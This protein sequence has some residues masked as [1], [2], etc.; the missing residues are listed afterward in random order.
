V[1]D[2]DAAI[3]GGPPGTSAM[4][5]VARKTAEAQGRLDALAAAGQPFVPKYRTLRN[6]AEERQRTLDAAMGA[7]WQAMTLDTFNAYTQELRVAAGSV[8]GFIEEPRGILYLYGDMGT[9]KTHLA[10]GTAIRLVERGYPVRVYRASDIVTSI[11]VALREKNLDVLMGRLKHVRV[12]V[13]DDFGAEHMTDFLAA[14]WF[15]LLDYRY[16]QY[17]A[18]IITSNVKPDNLGMPRL[19]SRF[20]DTK[21][22]VVVGITARDYRLMKKQPAMSV[23]ASD[24]APPP[25]DT[26]PCTTCGGLGTVKRDLAIGHPWFGRAF[27][28]PTCRGGGD[29]LK[30]GGDR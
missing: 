21:N 5:W 7:D 4:A 22:A 12:L 20:S 19:T 10:A 23:T 9:G 29:P 15:D 17:A 28:C 14:E 11:H 18:T 1:R 13:I 30:N 26:A 25:N 27:P 3:V 2:F 8:A 24:F 16:R 6:P